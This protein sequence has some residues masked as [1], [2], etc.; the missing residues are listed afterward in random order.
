MQR[1][2]LFTISLAVILITALLTFGLNY[3]GIKNMQINGKNYKPGRWPEADS[4][5]NQARQIY[6]TRKLSREN[7]SVGPCLTNALM[8]GWVLDLVHVPRIAIDDLPEN[9]CQEYSEGKSNHFVEL[10][11]EG[12]LVRAK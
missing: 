11:I 9:Q 12:D 1:N 8:N 6:Q 3:Q 5:I 4:A 10:S 7:L 2:L